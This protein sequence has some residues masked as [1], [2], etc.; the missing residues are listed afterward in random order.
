M[1]RN[2]IAAVFSRRKGKCSPSPEAA[3]GQTNS[4]AVVPV[5]E[6][7]FKKKKKKKE[8]RRSLEDHEFSVN[9]LP[10][11]MSHKASHLPSDSDKKLVLFR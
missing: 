7:S 11:Q 8:R 5:T 9:M 3:E 2:L 4:K 10:N 1:T 6:D